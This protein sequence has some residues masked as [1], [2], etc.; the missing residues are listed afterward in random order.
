MTEINVPFETIF[1]D[2][3]VKDFRFHSQTEQQNQAD[4]M[5]TAK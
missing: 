4:S 3:H 5:I 2:N 1:P